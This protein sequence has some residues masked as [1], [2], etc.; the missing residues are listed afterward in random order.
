MRGA[1]G[2]CRLLQCETVCGSVIH[3]VTLCYSVVAIEVEY[4]QQQV[5]AVCC[6]LLQSVAVYYS[7]LQRVA[8]F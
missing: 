3:D 7:V 8:V 5:A 1:A 4:V 2:C 6:S